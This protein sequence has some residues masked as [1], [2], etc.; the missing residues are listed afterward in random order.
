MRHKPRKRGRWLNLTET[1]STPRQRFE[2]LR[3]AACGGNHQPRGFI[4][5]GGAVT[6]T[7]G[8]PRPGSGIVERYPHKLAFRGEVR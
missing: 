6:F 7:K 1:G 2:W 4:G 5:D 3:L 8:T